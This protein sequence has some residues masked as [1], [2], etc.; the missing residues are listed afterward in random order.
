LELKEKNKSTLQ[1]IAD[2]MSYNYVSSSFKR[3]ELVDNKDSNLK[4]NFA[5]KFFLDPEGFLNRMGKVKEWRSIAIFGAGASY[6]AFKSIPLANKFIEIL[7]EKENFSFKEI[8]KLGPIH[9]RYKYLASKLDDHKTKFNSEEKLD[10]ETE[11]S[12]LSNIYDENSIK[13]L[14]KEIYGFRYPVSP[15][16]EF[17]AHMFR[18]RMMDVILN[19][20]FDEILEQAIEEEIGNENYHLVISDG[21]CKSLQ[22]FLVE[23]RLKAPIY[24]KPHGTASH[25]STLRFTKDSYFNI[26]P[27]M[28]ILIKGIFNGQFSD[29][30]NDDSDLERINV[31]V[32]GFGMKSIELNRI[33]IEILEDKKKVIHIYYFDL[34]NNREKVLKN[35][36]LTGND[37]LDNSKHLKLKFIGIDDNY[38]LINCLEDLWSY[39]DGNFIPKYKPRGL[40]RH[41]IVLDLF[42]RKN[43]AI[44]DAIDGV[45]TKAGF[46]NSYFKESEYFYD[47][48]IIEVA[49]ALI[50]SKG[51]IELA[52]LMEERV[53]MFY[54]LYREKKKNNFVELSEICEEIFGLKQEKSYGRNLY[55]F[56]RKENKNMKKSENSPY[57]NLSKHI[58]ELLS[59]FAHYTEKPKLKFSGSLKKTITRISK[60]KDTMIKYF[61]ELYFSFTSD[62]KFNFTD[63]SFYIFDSCKKENI[64]H[65]NLALTYNFYDQLSNE[66]EWSHLISIS[67]RGKLIERIKHWDLELFNSLQQSDKKIFLITADVTDDSLKNKNNISRLL[68]NNTVHELPY[69]FHND[70]MAV[71]LKEKENVKEDNEK[72]LCET[73]CK[74]F[75]FVKSI[76]Y[77][78][79]GYDNKINPVLFNGEGS[80]KKNHLMLLEKFW[81][82]YKSS[83]VYS[84]PKATYPKKLLHFRNQ[85]EIQEELKEQLKDV[86]TGKLKIV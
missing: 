74:N 64:L 73:Y 69:W 46:L 66:K 10:F 26:P 76:Y 54:D 3:S 85:E 77:H 44:L 39:I 38:K 84:N 50:K 62:I 12:V 56:P 7:K 82:Y 86:L 8:M 40:A 25:N 45:N 41:N 27:E 68:V 33:L 47:R 4:L 59:N 18:H 61:D 49:I 17:I 60:E 6:S 15:V 13:Q 53:G 34:E 79:N 2:I 80:N 31:F 1:E 28:N 71:F 23:D 63:K 43:D 78:R 21:H 22:E 35:K 9:D 83:I 30:P 16:Y 5:E 37:D 29:K 72:S 20:N 70:H 24:I 57:K 65:T 32:L 11:L 81:A 42:Y 48:T 52:S 58:W 55:S 51:H 19:F 36:K 75:F 67:E 14:L